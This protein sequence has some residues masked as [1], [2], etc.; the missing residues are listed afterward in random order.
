MQS[1]SLT[2]GGLY[3]FLSTLEAAAGD[4]VTIYVEPAYFSDYIDGLSLGPRYAAYADGIKA[5]V[6]TDPVT[7][8]ARKYGTGVAI[9]WNQA[10]NNYLVLPPFPVTENKVSVGE[11][12]T[13]LLREAL[14]KRYVV[15]VVLVTWG[16][17]AIG[18]F[19]AGNLVESKTGTGFIHKEHRKGGRSE[20]RFARRTEEQKKDFLRR[21]STRIEERFGGFALDHIFFGGNKLISKPLLRECRYLQSKALMV[22]PRVLDVRY[23]DREALANSLAEITK[24][25]VLSF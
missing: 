20:K 19:D 17:Y 4:F 12:N 25:L 14:G 15:G 7:Q 23:A 24:S 3:R 13:S 1:R 11:L 10:G 5:A 6:H 9:F 21:V 8:S 16:S 18:V 22:S 2:K